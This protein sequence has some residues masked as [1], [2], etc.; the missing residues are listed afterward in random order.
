M[1]AF[2]HIGDVCEATF[3][4]MK[5]AEPPNVYHLTTRD[6]HSIRGIVGAILEQMGVP[7]ENH[8]E[9]TED[10]PAKDM[11]YTLLPDKAEKEFGWTAD[12]SLRAGIKE[13]VD[14][15]E[16]FKEFLMKEPLQYIHK[17]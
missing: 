3:R 16:R 11:A 5:E 7:F 2:I 1:R 13:T 4:I 15:V 17:P 10:A 12:T 9:V 14:W 6:F 8:V